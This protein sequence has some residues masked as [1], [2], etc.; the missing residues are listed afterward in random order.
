[1]KRFW[2]FI[3]TFSLIEWIGRHPAMAAGVLTLLGVGGSAGI[4][5]LLTP[6]LLPQPAAY[7]NQ[8]QPGGLVNLGL[9]SA[10]SSMDLPSADPVGSFGLLFN[11]GVDSHLG[12]GVSSE[13]PFF[14]MSL[15]ANNNPG[16]PK[17]LFQKTS[18]GQ[19]WWTAPG[20]SVANTNP[21]LSGTQSNYA[22]VFNVGTPTGTACARAP[23]YVWL[24]GGTGVYESD[25]GFLCPTQLTGYDP[26]NIPGSGAR[27]TTSGTT[28]AVVGSQMQVTTTL[29][30]AHGLTPGMTYT[31]QG[32]TPSGYNATYTAIPGTA[33]GTLV[34]TTGAGSCPAV[35]SAE[36]TALNGAGVTITAPAMNLANPWIVGE[37]GITTKN[38]QHGCGLLTQYGDE[39]AFPGAQA[40]AMIDD[41]GNP[42]PGSPALVPW[43]NLG[44]ANAT[45]YLV[46]TPQPALVITAMNSYSVSSWTYSGSTG[47]VTFTLGSNPGFVPGS[48]FTVSGSSGGANQTYVAVAGTSGLTVVGNPL[49]GPAGTPLANNP[50]ASGTGGSLVSVILPGMQVLGAQVGS[51]STMIISPYGLNGGSG[52]GGVGSYA[53]NNLPNGETLTGTIAASS[54]QLVVTG[55]PTYPIVVGTTLTTVAGLAAGTT[56]TSIGTATGGVGTYTLSNSNTSGSTITNP[57]TTGAIGSAG[58]PVTL[59]LYPG[60]FYNAAAAPTSTNLGGGTVTAKTAAAQGDFINVFGTGSTTAP[61]TTK[62]GWGGDLSDI[63]LLYMPG[64]FPTQSGGA[65]STASLASLCKKQTD[66]QDFATANGFTVE[67]NYRLNDAGVWG[68]SSNA[69]I[70]GY[71]TNSPGPNNATLNIVSTVHG[72]LAL[73]SGIQTAR[74]AGPGLNPATSITIPLTTSASSTY[75]IT[76]NTTAALGSI[77]SPVTFSV[78]RFAP[79]TPLTSGAFAGSIAT[80]GGVSTLHRRLDGRRRNA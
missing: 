46:A 44:D 9:K 45:G 36:G 23:T 6:P 71:I 77:G 56:V 32:F 31:M 61:S 27:Q 43:L 75:A 15:V 10:T 14:G 70:T 40:I 25:P 59:F 29:A 26:V 19:Q 52:T 39:S 41:A 65:P 20:P 2:I 57:T 47:Y 18:T 72:S 3:S 34:G 79:M 60:F 11:F 38:G 64:G 22:T 17:F 74:L 7:F 80:S 28:C 12:Y 69:V 33:G 66:V 49:S 53:T 5:N 30:V 37:T 21:T 1:M 51:P 73:A 68:D 58:S 55:A 35:V 8:N 78:G 48:E 63:A 76:P 4:A 16:T 50:G 42:F 54:N 24:G 62:G 67:T 13:A